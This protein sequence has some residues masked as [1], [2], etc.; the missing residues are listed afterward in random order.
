MNDTANSASDGQSAAERLLEDSW[1]GRGR[2]ASQRE[3]LAELAA[4]VAFIAAATGLVAVAGA[5]RGLHLGVAALFVAL[6]TVVARIE[7]PV[8]PGPVVPTQLVLVPMLVVLPPS[9]IPTLVA[10]GLV[11]SSVLDCS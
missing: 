9:A 11:A 1:E 8:G 4:A 5:S 2:R 7:F 6:Y 3:I 10:A